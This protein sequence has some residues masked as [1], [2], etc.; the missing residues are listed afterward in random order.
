MFESE[1][2]MAH[3]VNSN[4]EI[5]LAELQEVVDSADNEIALDSNLRYYTFMRPNEDEAD[6]E[7]LHSF[8]KRGHERKK[9]VNRELVQ[10]KVPGISNYSDSLMIKMNKKIK[11]VVESLITL[12]KQRFV[13][14]KCETFLTHGLVRSQIME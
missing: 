9:P 14:D 6:T 2:L 3:E 4:M 11:E 10:I 13:D 8:F 5:T 12:L 1:D 7:A